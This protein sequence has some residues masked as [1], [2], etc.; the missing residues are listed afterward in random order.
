[1]Q[2][3]VA[4]GNPGKLQEYRELLADL[5]VEWLSLQDAG[6]ADMDVEETGRSFEEN[7]RLKA[8]AYHA[9]S[10]LLTL[11][12]DS[13]LVVDALGGAPGIYSARYGAPE[14]KT[15]EDRYTKLLSALE[16]VPDNQRRAHFVCIIAIAA[17]GFPL[18]TVEGRVAGHIAR[19]PR[20]SHGF[21][22]DPVFV[23]ED[24][25]TAAELPPE[26]KH[27]IS[28]RGEALRAALPVLKRITGTG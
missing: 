21:G 11:A 13:G 9:A 26:E 20:G 18:Q 22:Y 15:D 23:T 10:G 25:R 1:M 14:A 27:R 3:L 4:T 24:G 6:L 12:D 28:H 2:L 5:P 8:S 16:N 17:P 7:A 19:A